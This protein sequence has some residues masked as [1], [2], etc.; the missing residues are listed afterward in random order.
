V[1][2]VSWSPSGTSV[3]V[4]TNVFGWRLELPEHHLVGHEWGLRS[5]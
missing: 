4:L 3:V 1:E 2:S 5:D